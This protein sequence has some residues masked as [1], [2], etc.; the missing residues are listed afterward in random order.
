MSRA[1]ALTPL[2]VVV[3]FLVLVGAGLG[4]FQVPNM[5]FVMAS[6]DR[7]KQGLAGG[8]TQMTRTV[9]LVAG[10][11]V[12]NTLYIILRDRKAAELSISELEDPRIFV[13]AYSAVLGLAGLL[14]LLGTLAT[15]QKRAT[16]NDLPDVPSCK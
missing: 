14:C 8:I 3:I 10:L 13:P 11:A 16:I 12:W 2:P 7:T 5:S 1:T 9:G 4:L 6:I 15:R